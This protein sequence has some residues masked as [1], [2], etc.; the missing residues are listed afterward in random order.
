MTRP[1]QAPTAHRS[2]QNLPDAPQDTTAPSPS[3]G[4]LAVQDPPTTTAS[5]SPVK[6]LRPQRDRKPNTRL[7]P[8]E[9]ELG[10]MDSAQ[11]FVPTMDWCLDMIRWIAKVGGGGG[12]R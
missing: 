6:N 11:Q 8:A 5:P 10:K 7:N 12:R 1:D 9:W 3:Q 4:Y 2:E